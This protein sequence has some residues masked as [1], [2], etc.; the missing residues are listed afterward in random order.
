MVIHRYG[1]ALAV[2]IPSE[3]VHEMGVVPGDTVFFEREPDGLH[4]RIF[5]RSTLVE[6]ANGQAE[7]EATEAAE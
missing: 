6:F 1:R 5:Q 4:L 7:Q 2:S 3:Y